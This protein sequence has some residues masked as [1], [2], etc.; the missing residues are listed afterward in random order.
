MPGRGGLRLN[1]LRAATSCEIKR[2]AEVSSR[3]PD[4]GEEIV[5]WVLMEIAT[6]QRTCLHFLRSNS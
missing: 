5:N 1:E 6:G 4:Y 2:I 3:I